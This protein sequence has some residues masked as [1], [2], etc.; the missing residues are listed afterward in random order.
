MSTAVCVIYLLTTMTGGDPAGVAC[1]DD[2]SVLESQPVAEQEESAT[3][4]VAPKFWTRRGCR[5]P[6][7]L[8]YI[9]TNCMTK[10]YTLRGEV[11]ARQPYNY[12][13]QF[14]Y[15]WHPEC[16]CPRCAGCGILAYRV[17]GPNGALAPLPPLDA[18]SMVDD[19]TNRPSAIRK[20]D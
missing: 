14:D 3:W 6:E 1:A 8:L 2:A 20:V 7:P 4:F 16:G 11:Y 15:P 9:D 5:M 12:L 10:W 18:A 13:V 19:R 17:L